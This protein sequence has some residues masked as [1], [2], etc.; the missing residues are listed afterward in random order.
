M[1]T[2]AEAS[3]VGVGC[4]THRVTPTPATP[5]LEEAGRSRE[6][7][8]GGWDRMVGETAMQSATGRG[9]ECETLREELDTEWWT[10]ASMRNCL[11]MREINLWQKM[12]RDT[13]TQGGRT[14]RN[15][16]KKWEIT[17]ELDLID[18]R[19]IYKKGSRDWE[20]KRKTKME[21]KRKE[22]KERKTSDKGR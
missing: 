4:G 22:K 10:R 20:R 2:Q 8:T 1:K 19:G 17:N 15:R 11:R 7:R 12:E 9:K 21:R 5:L 18:Y 3:L 14:F 6:G 13:H 16:N